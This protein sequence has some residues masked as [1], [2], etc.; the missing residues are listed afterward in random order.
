MNISD[1]EENKRLLLE[2]WWLLH[3]LQEDKENYEPELWRNSNER[4][5]ES[6]KQ[7]EI[8]LNSISEYQ[9]FEDDLVLVLH[10]ID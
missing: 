1:F 8:Q 5:K 9:E 2:H 3:R 10:P 6:I 4:I 7:L